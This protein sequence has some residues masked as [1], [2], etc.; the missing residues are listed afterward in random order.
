MQK[1]LVMELK[2]AIENIYGKLWEQ[3]SRMT[4]E[5]ASLLKA[6]LDDSEVVC[7]YAL[8]LIMNSSVR[9]KK[10]F[11]QGYDELQNEAFSLLNDAI[12]K[13][14]VMALNFMAQ[15]KCGLFGKFPRYPDEGKALFEKYYEL[16]GCETTKTEILDD[17]EAYEEEMKNHF[18]DMKI[19]EVMNDLRN[20]GF[21]EF[22]SH[23]EAYYEE[24]DND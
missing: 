10:I 5:E 18:Y 17:W 2:E 21:T 23:D 6:N 12:K 3:G 7:L 4:E 15:I 14:N 20:Q 24:Q 19:Y 8:G 9:Y 1:E 13:G 16:T 22:S 11:F